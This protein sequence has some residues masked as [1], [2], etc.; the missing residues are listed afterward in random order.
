MLAKSIEYIPAHPSNYTKGRG[1]RRIRAITVHHMAAR[2]TAKRCG[3]SFQQIERDAS[4]HYGIGFEGEIA[5][6][7]DEKDTA[8]TNGDWDSNL[9]SVTIECA[10]SAMGEPW[11]V[12]DATLNSLIDLVADIAKRNGLVPLVKGVNFT[13]HQMFDA[14][15]CPGDYLLSKMDYIVEEAN[16]RVGDGEGEEEG[17]SVSYR[18][19][20]DRW[21]PA[22]TG[23]DAGDEDNGYAGVLGAPVFG[24]QVIASVGDVWYQAHPKG[25]SNWLPEVR[26]NEDYAGTKITPMD[27]F[28]IQSDSTVIRYRVHTLED[29]WLPEVTGYDPND[30]DNG[31]AG[32]FG[33]VIDAIMIRADEIIEAE[34]EE[35]EEAEQAPAPPVEAEPESPPD[36]PPSERT[37]TPVFEEEENTQATTSPKEEKPTRFNFFALLARLIEALINFLKKEN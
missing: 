36:I 15:S 27:G 14:T 19:H 5:R 8:W 17:I 18:V 16:K 22:V 26:N 23:A 30:H 13:W 3:E 31:Y 29:G 20:T 28:M 4:S 24:V 12:S 1:G 2:W 21:L 25:A 35:I 34:E 6:Y 37:E 32:V 7:V 11:P 33:H 9:E 10:N